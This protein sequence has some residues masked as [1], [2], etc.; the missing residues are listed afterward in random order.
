MMPSL[1]ERAENQITVYKEPVIHGPIIDSQANGMQM[2]LNVTMFTVAAFPNAFQ[3]QTAA[4]V[5][6]CVAPTPS[7][8]RG[9]TR[10]A[11]NEQLV[12]LQP[13]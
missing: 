12:G 5:A 8:A 3:L 1:H 6:I 4:N 9:Q 13:L 7:G 10:A 11:Y 2:R